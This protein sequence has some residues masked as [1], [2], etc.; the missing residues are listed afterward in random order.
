MNTYKR[1]VG[2]PTVKDKKKRC[3]VRVYSSD[4]ELLKSKGMT[5]QQVIDTTL[6]DYRINQ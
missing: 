1:P 4:L 6:S 3:S 5:L 2:R